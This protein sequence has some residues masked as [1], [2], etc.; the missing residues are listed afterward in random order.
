MG[1]ELDLGR[2]SRPLPLDRSFEYGIMARERSEILAAH[3]EW[4][5][6][7]RSRSGRNDQAP[8]ALTTMSVMKP[9][10]RPR[11]T[12]QTS[13]CLLPALNATLSSCMTT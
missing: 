12:P 3:Q 10:A 5:G 2:G 8:A 9:A 4:M 7:R 13:S 11:N 6:G 1:A